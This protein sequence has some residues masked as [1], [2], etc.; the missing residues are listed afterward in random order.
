VY[1]DKGSMATVGKNKAVAEIF[2]WKIGGFMAW[3]MWMFI[4]LMSLVG[5]RNKIIV[6]FDWFVHY[7]NLDRGIRLIIR[8]FDMHEARRKRKREMDKEK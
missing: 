5:F 3:L 8:P 6:F 4:H 7:F 2:G 1:R